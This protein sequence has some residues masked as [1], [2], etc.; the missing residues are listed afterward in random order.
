[1]MCSVFGSQLISTRHIHSVQFIQES[2]ETTFHV[3]LTYNDL[4][5]V[6]VCVIIHQ[7]S[8]THLTDNQTNKKCQKLTVDF[9]VLVLTILNS[10]DVQCGSVW[11]NQ[12]IRFL[13]KRADEVLITTHGDTG[14]PRDHPTGTECVSE[15]FL[16]IGLIL[17]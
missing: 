8:Y 10:S 12:S 11:E 13:K 5:Y 15:G 6:T 1:M 3:L 2:S 16:N 7:Y 4:R 17:C 9:I 14:T